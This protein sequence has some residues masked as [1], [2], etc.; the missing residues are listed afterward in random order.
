V[1]AGECIQYGS[2]DERLSVFRNIIECVTRAYDPP[3]YMIAE[4]RNDIYPIVVSSDAWVSFVHLTGE[5]YPFP[6]LLV[7]E[8]P[9]FVLC[10]S[11][12]DMFC[13]I[14]EIEESLSR[15]RQTQ[16]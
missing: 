8:V 14:G 1:G 6:Y 11:I 9:S 12:H 13:A 4:L 10:E 16:S 2:S 3:G 15:L 7:D 5:M